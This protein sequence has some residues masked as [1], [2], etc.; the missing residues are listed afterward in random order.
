[1]FGARGVGK[2]TYLRD[3]F[4]KNKPALSINL[5]EPKE[6]DIYLKNP[7]ELFRRV[8]A[9]SPS[10]NSQWVFIDEIQ[11]LPSILDV[12]HTLIEE[13]RFL[14]ALTGSS[15][16]K[17]K[18]GAANLLA[19]RA[20]VYHLFPLSFSELR[21]EFELQSV[22]EWGS[23]P[24]VFELSGQDKQEFL[25]AYTQTYLKEEILEEQIIRNIRPFRRFLEIAAQSSGQIIN[26][27]NIARD[28]G[29]DPVSVQKYFQILEDTLLGFHLEPFHESI[30]K[31]QRS[32]PKFYLFDLGVKRAL[33]GTLGVSL[34]ES[35][36]AYGLSFEH[37]VIQEIIRL[38]S[39]ARKNWKFSY[40]RTK[41]DAEVDLIIDRPG[42]SR[43]AI[44][45]KSS[46]L[47]RESDMSS[48]AKISKDIP[49]SKV[50]CLSRD[51]NRKKIE[52]IECLFWQEGIQSILEE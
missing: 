49:N 12:V 42:L 2:T 30:R 31:R 41:D 4:F 44:E 1:M 39:Y 13:K 19:G 22:L 29:S 40:L 25:I 9:I 38:S 18:R 24:R 17:L 27:S 28:C 21:N 7:D 26:Y 14:F 37:L 11:K 32:N 20:F 34:I 36:G 8:A 47:I 15:A 51:P 23:L 50:Y 33:D 48:F 3:Q 52:H 46:K 45:I 16:R 5:L 43:V 35:T 6:Y 10:K